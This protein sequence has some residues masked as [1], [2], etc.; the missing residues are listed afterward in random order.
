MEVF[1]H[2]QKHRSLSFKLTNED[3]K[4][5]KLAEM[6]FPSG[7]WICITIDGAERDVGWIVVCRFKIKAVN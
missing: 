5:F 4:L 2:P 1:S 7:Y 3:L 6:E